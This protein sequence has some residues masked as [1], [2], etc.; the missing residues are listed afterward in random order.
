MPTF[1]YRAKKKSGETV[2]GDIEAQSEDEAIELMNRQDLVP[3]SLE[4]KTKTEN[5]F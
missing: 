1:Q 4:S 2:Y 5:Y 3:I